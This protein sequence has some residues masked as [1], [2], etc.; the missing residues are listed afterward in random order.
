MTATIDTH[1]WWWL[2][3]ASGII[4]WLVVA[5]AVVWGLLASTKFI[6]RRGVPAW[7]LDLH[8]YLGTLT[9]VFV[10]VHVGAIWADSFVKFGPRQLFVPLASTWRPRAVAWGIVSA[11]LLVAIQTTSWAMRTLPRRLWHRIHLMSIP[12]IAMATVHGFL[13]G[14]D[15]GNRALQWSAF[16]VL[17]GVLFLLSVRVISPSRPARGA[18]VANRERRP[19]VDQREVAV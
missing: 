14:T 5:A 16:V 10:A 2:S 12:M 9:I 8:R 6:R 18:A 13:A 11:Y 4:A 3:R 1:A 17:I 7:I 19:Q 15:R